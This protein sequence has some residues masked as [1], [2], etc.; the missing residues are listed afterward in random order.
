MV[1]PESPGRTTAAPFPFAGGQERVNQL[2]ITVC[3]LPLPFRGG[4]DVFYAGRSAQRLDQHVQES[5]SAGRFPR[6]RRTPAWLGLEAGLS[7]S[8]TSRQWAGVYFPLF[9]IFPPDSRREYSSASVWSI[10]HRSCFDGVREDCGT[11]ASTISMHSA[12]AVAVS[13]SSCGLFHLFVPPGPEI[14]AQLNHRSA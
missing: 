4:D 5:R 11:A 13:P 7:I 2:S 10:T 1:L 6:R 3:R 14:F 12:I 8:A 9:S